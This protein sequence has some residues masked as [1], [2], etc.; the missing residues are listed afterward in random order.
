MD[1]LNSVVFD[2][3]FCGIVLGLLFVLFDF[4]D[5]VFCFVIVV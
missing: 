5:D 3:S 1:L 2:N 4:I